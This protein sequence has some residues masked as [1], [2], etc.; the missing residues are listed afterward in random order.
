MVCRACVSS[1]EAAHCVSAA[2]MLRV[3][4]RSRPTAAPSR[5]HE[6]ERECVRSG[7]GAPRVTQGAEPRA[8]RERAAL[9]V[10]ELVAGL[11]LAASFLAGTA[12]EPVGAPVVVLDRAPGEEAGTSLQRGPAGLDAAAVRD[13]VD[14]KVRDPRAE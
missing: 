3:P 9:G 8:T 7:S 6:D 13:G 2:R 12:H 11:A 1:R 5:E 14:R 4:N 10:P